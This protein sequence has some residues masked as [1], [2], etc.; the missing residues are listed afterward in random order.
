MKN[1]AATTDA[2]ARLRRIRT[3]AW[4][5]DN[6]I[7]LPG[8]YRVGVD[9]LIGLVPGLGD[10]LGAALSAYIINEARV[11][12]APRSVLMRMTLNVLIE[13]VLGAV[14]LAGDILD[15]AFKANMRNLDLLAKHELDPLGARRGSR[16]FI[17]GCVFAL[18]VLTVAMMAIPVLIVVAITRSL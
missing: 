4:L 9:A 8:G 6:S 14:P 3:L 12:G 5:L 16:L 1:A 10:A 13:T 11:L 17:L 7:P 18:A 2:N 15:A